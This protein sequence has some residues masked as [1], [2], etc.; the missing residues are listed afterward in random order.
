[1]LNYLSADRAIMRGNLLLQAGLRVVIAV[2]IAELG[3]PLTRARV[4]QRRA[5]IE[6]FD[7][8]RRRIPRAIKSGIIGLAW[9]RAG[10]FDFLTL[11]AIR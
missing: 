4:F 8:E 3:D 7:Y 2:V 5:R 9:A 6:K 10:S 11:R 1:M